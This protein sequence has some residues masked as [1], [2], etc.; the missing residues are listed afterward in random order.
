[1][2][3]LPYWPAAARPKGPF[4]VDGRGV[5]ESR[6][7]LYPLVGLE[8]PQLLRQLDRI[9]PPAD[10]GVAV[11]DVPAKLGGVPPASLAQALA[12]MGELSVDALDD[13]PGRDWNDGHFLFFLLGGAAP[14]VCGHWVL[15]RP[16]RTLRGRPMCAEVGRDCFLVVF[17]PVLDLLMSAKHLLFAA[18]WAR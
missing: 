3:A 7:P 6:S 5:L 9:E 4:K 13:G 16:R 15:T 2:T 8:H 11:D 10:H 18:K 12:A 1:M 17:R 14:A